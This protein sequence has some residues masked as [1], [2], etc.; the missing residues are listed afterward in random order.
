MRHNLIV[1][2]IRDS[3]PSGTVI[4]KP[5]SKAEF[6]VKS[7]GRR[8]GEQALVYAIPNHKDPERPHEK[9]ITQTEFERA[10]VEL[11]RAGA[12]TRTWFNKNL[13]KCAEEGSCNY[14]TVGGIFELL[15]EAK[16]LG[17]G[18]YARCNK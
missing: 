4:P 13:P 6:F 12:L 5:N 9:G 7:W 2:K 10:Y 11:Q 14:T 17:K 16:Y 15:G 3:V 1:E 8:R 18:I